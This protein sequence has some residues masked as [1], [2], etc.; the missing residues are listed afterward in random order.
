MIGKKDTCPMLLIK[1]GQPGPPFPE[2]LG[3]RPADAGRVRDRLGSDHAL[4]AGSP[5]P[6]GVCEWD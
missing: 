6:T 4:L 2:V 1:G 5:I 3:P